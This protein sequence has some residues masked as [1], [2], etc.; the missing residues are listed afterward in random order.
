LVAII[1]GTAFVVGGSMMIG[2]SFLFKNSFLAEIS[3]RPVALIVSL[4]AVAI[5]LAVAS[6]VIWLGGR[7][8]AGSFRPIRKG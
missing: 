2:T 4:F 6:F 5:A 8:L 3:S 1:F 7:L